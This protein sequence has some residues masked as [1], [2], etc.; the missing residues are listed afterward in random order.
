[1]GGCEIL[2]ASN[3]VADSPEG[4]GVTAF[5][6]AEN[7]LLRQSVKSGDGIEILNLLHSASGWL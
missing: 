6:D 3:C 2:A 7:L 1:M 4:V 5:N